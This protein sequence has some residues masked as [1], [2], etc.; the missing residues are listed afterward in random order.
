MGNSTKRI[1][2]YFLIFCFS[3]DYIPQNVQVKHHPFKSPNCFFFE[4]PRIPTSAV[5]LLNS[6]CNPILEQP[7]AWAP[8]PIYPY[9]TSEQKHFTNFDDIKTLL[10]QREGHF[11]RWVKHNPFWRG[12]NLMRKCWA[13]WF[14]ILPSR[15]GTCLRLFHAMTSVILL[16]ETWM[17]ST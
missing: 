2:F 9:G 5:F 7:P 8:D 12:S 11:F 10:K 3:W 6:I 17:N 16:H 13:L 1:V 4:I 14:V 15:I